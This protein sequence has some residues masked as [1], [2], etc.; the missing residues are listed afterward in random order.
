MKV[1]I[2]LLFFSMSNSLQATEIISEDPAN[3]YYDAF[4][5]RNTIC[6]QA[7]EID[8]TL[9]FLHHDNLL[10]RNYHVPFLIA[11][12]Y[13]HTLIKCALAVKKQAEL[14]FEYHKHTL[15][16]CL[17]TTKDL[18]IC[19]EFIDQLLDA[20]DAAELDFDESNTIRKKGTQ[21]LK[22]KP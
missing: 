3:R 17:N 8:T 7:E 19:T 11:N 4:D 20:L 18:S 16:I 9:K 15:D 2:F 5:H 6:A 10:Q 12:T 13:G 1:F 22:I 14:R 21:I